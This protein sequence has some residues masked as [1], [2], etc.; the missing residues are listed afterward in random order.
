MAGKNFIWNLQG[1]SSIEVSR[2]SLGAMKREENQ[3]DMAILT[4]IIGFGLQ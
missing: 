3:D 4:T 1:T 2:G